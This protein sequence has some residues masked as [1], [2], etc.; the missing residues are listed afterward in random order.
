MAKKSNRKW[1]PPKLR[2]TREGRYYIALTLGVGLAALNTGNNLLYLVLGVQLA[3]IVA[4][5]VV[6][7]VALY[8]LK[9]TRLLPNYG[10][11]GKP[12]TV[13]IQVFNGKPRAISYAI[14]IEDKREQLGADKRCFFLKIAP[15][16]SQIAA[17]RRTVER[18]GYVRY[19]GFR[20][21]TRYPFG[22]FEKSFEKDAPA[23]MVIVPNVRRVRIAGDEA[24]NGEIENRPQRGAVGDWYSFKELAQG[25]D[26]RAIHWKKSASREEPIV[27]EYASQ[28]S[29]EIHLAIPD[30]EGKTAEQ[31]DEEVEYCASLAYS[32]L[33]SGHRVLLE[34]RGDLR[35]S[36]ERIED[37][38]E[39]LIFL[40]TWGLEP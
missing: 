19:K 5:G 34:W 12:H 22:L 24:G 30:P 26:P 25:D 7:E 23:T 31:L 2:I 39:V 38:S 32:H 21:V 14:E 28:H 17:Y 40:G 27:R 13:E 10:V 33:E 36:A 6:S 37:L 11:A 9:V 29:A 20:V 16:S 1:S 15:G 18:R 35:V 3:L 4:S 8:R